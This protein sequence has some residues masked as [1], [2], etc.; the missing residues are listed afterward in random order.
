VSLAHYADAVII[1]ALT[2][3]VVAGALALVAL[4]LI[5]VAMIRQAGMRRQY[6]ILQGRD[7]TESFLAAVARKT[8]EVETLRN[9]VD[10]LAQVL[11]RARV[12][13]SEAV[14]H[15]SVVRYDA[16]GDMGGRMSFSA[17]FLDDAGDGVVLT[18]I[19]ART[20]SRTY[21]KAVVQGRA[22]TLLSPEEVQAVEAAMRGSN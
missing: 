7:S 19:H 10:D 2:V 5:V 13:I 8:V 21:M 16:F 22:E 3:A 17:A 18:T 20:E 15:V 4:V 12:D 6:T 1:D 9:E 14:R 11:D